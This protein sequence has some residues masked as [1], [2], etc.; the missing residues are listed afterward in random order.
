MSLKKEKKDNN[1]GKE[2]GDSNYDVPCH[3]SVHCKVKQEDDEDDD[4]NNTTTRVLLLLPHQQQ[5]FPIQLL[6]VVAVI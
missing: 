1:N 2:T 3:G 4:K 5:W 6:V